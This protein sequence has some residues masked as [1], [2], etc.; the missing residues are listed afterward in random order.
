MGLAEGVFARAARSA[1]A[2]SDKRPLG[3][4]AARKIRMVQ[5]QYEKWLTT[6]ASNM[7]RVLTLHLLAQSNDFLS[8]G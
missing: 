8:L 1:A 3:L 7:S 2:S 4:D 6:R 5:G